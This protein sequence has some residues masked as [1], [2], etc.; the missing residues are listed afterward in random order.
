MQELSGLWQRWREEE[1]HWSELE[2]SSLS[3]HPDLPV[4]ILKILS[5][6]LWKYRGINLSWFSV[7]QWKP[8][9]CSSER[10][11]FLLTEEKLLQL[12]TTSSATEKHL[13]LSFLCNFVKTSVQTV[14][15]YIAYT[16]LLKLGWVLNT[17]RQQVH[18]NTLSGMLSSKQN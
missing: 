6:A 12:W 3:L 11:S 15:S 13:N 8:L 1:E 2:V 16:S 4:I 17:T 14:L 10:N 7:W 5:W 9:H 18:G